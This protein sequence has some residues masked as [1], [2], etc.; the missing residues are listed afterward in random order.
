M[1]AEKQ[2]TRLYIVLIALLL[3]AILAALIL[4]ALRPRAGVPQ[5]T[6]RPEPVSESRSESGRIVRVEKEVSAET[7]QGGLTDMGLLITGEYYFTEVVSFSSIKKYWK[8]ELKFTE[9]AFLA[10]YDGVV[11]AG[12][13]FSKL[14]V[15][16]DES[17]KRIRVHVPPAQIQSVDIDPESFRLYSEKEGLGNR[18]SVEDYNNSLLELESQARAKAEERGLL[19]RADENARTLIQRFIGGLVDLSV[20][21]VEFDAAA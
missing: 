9:S 7:I 10:S 13:D 8:L 1:L 2:K 18:I 4:A 20:Y 16:K 14:S 19:E 12:I 15:E 17:V 21:R 6:P 11:S 5:V 3:A